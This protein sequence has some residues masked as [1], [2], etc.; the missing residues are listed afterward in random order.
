MN[1]SLEYVGISFQRPSQHTLL[2]NCFTQPD[3]VSSPTYTEYCLATV[4]YWR[5][6]TLIGHTLHDG[7]LILLVLNSNEYYMLLLFPCWFPSLSFQKGTIHSTIK[8]TNSIHCLQFLVDAPARH[9]CPKILWCVRRLS[10][11]FQRKNLFSVHFTIFSENASM[12]K[13]TIHAIS[14]A[15]RGV[16][17]YQNSYRIFSRSLSQW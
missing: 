10:V 15:Q 13:Y 4:L 12:N 8:A 5:P 17:L 11:M 1:Q 7:I 9:S 3:S 2:D 16:L 6:G 14:A